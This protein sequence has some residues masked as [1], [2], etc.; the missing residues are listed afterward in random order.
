M[1]DWLVTL[2]L[3][4]AAFV[5]FY[6]LVVQPGPEPPKVLRPLTTEP[7]PNGYMGLVQWLRAQNLEPVVWR[8]RFNKLERSSIPPQGNLLLST[9]PFVYPPRNSEFAALQRWIEAG[10][11]LLLVASLADSPQWAPPSAQSVAVEAIQNMTGLKLSPQYD[12]VAT[13]E[14]A[15][16]LANDTMAA[17][18]EAPAAESEDAEV[19]DAADAPSGNAQGR[20]EAR[21][22]LQRR[23]LDQMMQPTD[24]ATIV[25]LVPEQAHPLLEGVSRVEAIARF[26]NHA[27]TLT[28]A[29]TPL[30]LELASSPQLQLPALWLARVGRGQVII[31]GLGSVFTNGQLGKADN[32]R[33]LANVVHWSLQGEGRILLDDAHQGSVEYYDPQAFF[34]D[35]RLHA[36][37]W[38]VMAL[39]LVFVLGPQ[40]LRMA[41][42]G[43][44]PADLTTFV[45]AIGG[46]TARVLQP[47]ATARQMFSL[48]FA[49]V[50]RRTGLPPQSEPP[51]QWLQAH[52]GADAADLSRLRQLYDQ[53]QR[54]RRVN[55]QQ[56]HNLLLRVR[57]S[58]LRH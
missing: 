21:R 30:V 40:R 51:W 58:W 6:T 32:A 19:P 55:L 35:S 15:E 12:R 11:T 20:D 57:S 37:L 34:G 2:V 4:L 48:F 16:A 17:A 29:T 39:W 49:E 1:K 43:W 52:A 31:S 26:A 50:H 44:R 7:G 22:S 45:R 27:W 47:A 46:F 23:L 38:W 41:N 56:L 10:N 42:P 14:S 13:R 8:D 24:E 53:V 3:A 28:P 25:E 18:E 54:D 36:T 5:A 33:L 9:A